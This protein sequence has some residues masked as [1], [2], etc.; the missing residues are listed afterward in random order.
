MIHTLYEDYFLTRTFLSPEAETEEIEL[1]DNI[2]AMKIR[3]INH[4]VGDEVQYEVRRIRDMH[5][6]LDYR[7]RA[8]E[9]AGNLPYTYFLINATAGEPRILMCPPPP[10]ESTLFE[11]WYIRNANR[12][13]TGSDTCDIP[14]F[15]EF[16]Y[17][18]VRMKVYL[19]EG[20][21]AYEA[22]VAHKEA[23][24][25]LMMETLAGMV[26]DNATEIEGD[27]SHYRNHV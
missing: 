24:K 10:L 20:H 7:I 12:L 1:P 17:A 16:V 22:S 2:Y 15:I 23:T 4:M 5:K 6:F 25:Q 3:G 27:L 11:C 26:P 9:D 14:E 18:H 21:H 13:T 19:K 8:N